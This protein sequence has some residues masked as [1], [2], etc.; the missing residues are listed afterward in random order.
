M[1]S[2]AAAGNVQ[3]IAVDRAKEVVQ[4]ACADANF[5]IVQS[6]RLHM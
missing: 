6:L 2:L 5:L 1:K 4:V 3:T